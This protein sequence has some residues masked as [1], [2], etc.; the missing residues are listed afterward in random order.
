MS[1]ALPGWAKSVAEELMIDQN[2]S[3]FVLGGDLSGFAS[4]NL[5]AFLLHR[6]PHKNDGTRN[7]W[8]PAK[9][10]CLEKNIPGSIYYQG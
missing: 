9:G 3:A 10:I 8:M 2:F 5:C 6:L 1:M 4:C 7:A